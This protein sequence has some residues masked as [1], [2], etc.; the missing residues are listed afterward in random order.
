MPPKRIFFILNFLRLDPG[1]WTVWPDR[2]ENQM[3]SELDN[4]PTHMG[5]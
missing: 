1:F 4:T 3:I 2:L 5:R